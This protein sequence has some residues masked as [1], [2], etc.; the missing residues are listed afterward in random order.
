MAVDI[1]AAWRHE[2]LFCWG[3]QKVF[4]QVVMGVRRPEAWVVA[5]HHH[6]DHQGT[7][8][9]QRGGIGPLCHKKRQNRGGEVPFYGRSASAERRNGTREEG[10]ERA[11]NTLL[12]H[13]ARSLL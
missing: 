10:A 7:E 8:F 9:P 6:L 1:A 13:I 5:C 11:S 2:V 4:D 3:Q 12:P